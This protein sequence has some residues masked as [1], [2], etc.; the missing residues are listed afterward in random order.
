MSGNRPYDRREEL[1]FYVLGTGFVPSPG[2]MRLS[3]HDRN[4]KWDNQS[5]KGTT[6]SSSKLNGRDIGTF[7]A[8][9]TLSSDN[10]TDDGSDD[11]DAWETFQR[12][13]ESTT[14]GPTPIALPIYHPDLARNGFTE[15]VSAGVGGMVHDGKG[16]ATVTVKY[17]EYKPPKPKP[18][19]K[20]KAKPAQTYANTDEGR[21]SPPDPNAERKAQ[22]AALLA[23]AK[24]P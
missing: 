22:V 16:G 23:E 19:V 12:L 21:R 18:A 4:E 2:V 11:F 14:N 10:V 7:T 8:T 9:H 20:A 24:K 5:A 1:D 15:V 13:I 17:Q 6:G 3:G